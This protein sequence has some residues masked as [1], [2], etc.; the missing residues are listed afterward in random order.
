MKHWKKIILSRDLSI[1]E[2]IKVIDTGAL[3]I[4]LVVDEQQRLIGT[5]TDGDVRRG[6][7][8][9]VSLDDP[10]DLVMNTH[11]T[12]VRAG[13]S[14]EDI[15]TL[16]R[17]KSLHQVPVVDQQGCLVGLEILEDLL[18]PRR[19][20]N[21]VVLM[22]GGM[23]TR[24]QPLTENCP[25]PMLQ[26]GGRPI[27]ET[28]LQNFIDLGFYRF[29][30]AVNYLADQIEEY[31]KDGSRW[32]VEISYLH[33]KQ[34]LGTAGALSLLPEVPEQPILV[35]NGDLLTKVDFGQI[36][37][38]HQ[39]HQAAATMC[40]REYDY[41]V[42]Y[43]VVKADRH[44]FTGIDEKP[45]QCFFV[46]AGVYALSPTTLQLIEPN[47]PLDMPV[48]FDRLVANGQETVVFPIREYWLD[49]GRMNDFERANGEFQ[50]IFK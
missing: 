43:G 13:D 19:R 10:T 27:L 37:Q 16:M 6:I 24:L 34:R 33:E 39:E 47:T 25:K 12:V 50:E 18:R 23:G 14:R 21:W 8:R 38:F 3:Q 28:I 44:R 40:V 32:G 45:I 48:L 29:F 31:F 17:Q 36:L 46:N 2:A 49:V 22:A 4:A 41:Q 5:V 15:L 1:R 35:M 9:D 30:L 20:D 11:P 42:P 7:L 26:V